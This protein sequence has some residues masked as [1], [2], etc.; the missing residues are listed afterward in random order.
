MLKCQIYGKLNIPCSA[1]SRWNGPISNL[2]EAI[3]VKNVS[4]IKDDNEINRNQLIKNENVKENNNV[5]NSTNQLKDNNVETIPYEWKIKISILNV[6]ADIKQGTDEKIICDFWLFSCYDML[7]GKNICNN[8][9]HY[10]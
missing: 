4:K 5:Q 10:K 7:S 6:E 8:K 9:I 3:K 1:K 2:I